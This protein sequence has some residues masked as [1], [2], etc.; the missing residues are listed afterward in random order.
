MVYL[1]TYTQPHSSPTPAMSILTHPSPAPKHL[2]LQ[3]HLYLHHTTCGSH[4][5]TQHPLSLLPPHAP[6][7]LTLPLLHLR[8]TLPLNFP[9]PH[10]PKRSNSL[11]PRP[12]PAKFPLPFLPASSYRLPCLKGN[13]AC[14]QPYGSKKGKHHTPQLRHQNRNNDRLASLRRLRFFKK[15]EETKSRRNSPGQSRSP[16]PMGRDDKTPLH[17]TRKLARSKSER[18]DGE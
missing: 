4:F 15:Q 5:F 3:P 9:L 8:P 16:P 2:S 17:Q 10:P 1:F 18:G 12:P 14:S 7:S 11:P 13:D 6:P